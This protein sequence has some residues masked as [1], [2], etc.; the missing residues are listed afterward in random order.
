MAITLSEMGTGP[1]DARSQ[2]LGWLQRYQLENPADVGVVRDAAA[3]VGTFPQPVD[4][5]A[6]EIERSQHFRQLL[7]VP[8]A[9]EQLA[10]QLRAREWLE[11]LA[12]ALDAGRDS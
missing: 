7:G 4:E 2:L 3:A 10:A 1:D 11:Q 12:V 8:S 5:P 9:A 6:Y